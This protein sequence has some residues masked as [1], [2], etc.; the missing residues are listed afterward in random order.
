[1]I[2]ED[3]DED[4]NY[5]YNFRN[6]RDREII[7]KQTGKPVWSFA[8]NGKRYIIYNNKKRFVD[9]IIFEKYWRMKTKTNKIIHIDGDP[10]N[11]DIDNL[12]LSRIEGKKEMKCWDRKNQCWS[13]YKISIEW[14]K[15][16][17]E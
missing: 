7:N 5:I 17:L 6:N 15:K 16:F 14:K 11:N 1:M 9:R 12:T 4:E 10:N 2:N 8:D 3:F 13:D